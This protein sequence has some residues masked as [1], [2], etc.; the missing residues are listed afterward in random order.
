MVIVKQQ[1]K[2]TTRYLD[3]K[4]TDLLRLELETLWVCILETKNK[5]IWN[6]KGIWYVCEKRKTNIRR[7]PDI[8]KIMKKEY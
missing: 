4:Q 7:N 5:V 3:P 2:K 1:L 8:Y 6:C